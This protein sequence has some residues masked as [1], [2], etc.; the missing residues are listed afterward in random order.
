MF[1]LFCFSARFVHFYLLKLCGLWFQLTTSKVSHGLY[2]I[3]NRLLLFILSAG[4]R[5]HNLDQLGF[6]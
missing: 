1:R 5:D 4:A 3:A 6:S 2:M